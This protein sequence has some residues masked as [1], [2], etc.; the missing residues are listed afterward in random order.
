[1]LQPIT[2]WSTRMT[3]EECSVGSVSEVV[4]CT[5]REFTGVLSEIGIVVISGGTSSSGD[6]CNGGDCGDGSCDGVGGDGG[7]GGCGDAGDYIKSN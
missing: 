1:M 3:T 5:H 6:G 7:G 2:W 4:K